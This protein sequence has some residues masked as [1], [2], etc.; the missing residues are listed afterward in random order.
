MKKRKPLSKDIL[1]R[2]SENSDLEKKAYA[3]G[4]YIHAN[5][6]LCG[7][8]YMIYAIQLVMEVPEADF[9]G[10][11]GVYARVAEKFHVQ[12]TSCIERGIRHLCEN[13]IKDMELS[14][15]EAIFGT[16]Q[17]LTNRRLIFSACNFIRY[18]SEKLPV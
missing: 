8:K 7:F 11:N 2:I 14:K 3:F 9:T 10:E 5:Q 16:T 15:Y 1:R 6:G 12:N 18:E 17:K 13:L 4:K